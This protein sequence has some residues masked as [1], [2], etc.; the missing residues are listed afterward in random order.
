M[1]DFDCK[2][3]VRTLEDAMLA[4]VANGRKS[5]K[6]EDLIILP[7]FRAQRDKAPIWNRY[8]PDAPPAR[9]DAMLLRTKLPADFGE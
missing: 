5:S 9:L 6:N 7:C 2:L 3:A 8:P 4:R 1:G